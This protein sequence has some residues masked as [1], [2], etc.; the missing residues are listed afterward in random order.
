MRCPNCECRGADAWLN[1]MGTF[2]VDCNECGEVSE[3]PSASRTLD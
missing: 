3:V 1:E 2:T